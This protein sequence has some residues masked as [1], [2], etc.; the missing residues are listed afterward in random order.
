[1]FEYTTSWTQLSFNR[2]HLAFY[3]FNPVTLSSHPSAWHIPLDTN[4]NV[5]RCMSRFHCDSWYCRPLKSCSRWY[6]ASFRLAFGR[7]NQLCYDAILYYWCFYF[8]PMNREFVMWDNAQF[9]LNCELQDGNTTSPPT[10]I[11]LRIRA[12]ESSTPKSL[13]VS[14]IWKLLLKQNDQLH[15]RR[16]SQRVMDVSQDLGEPHKIPSEDALPSNTSHLGKGKW[17]SKVPW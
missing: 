13:N 16:I 12:G 17:S 7:K 15:G 6:V 5:G 11:F 3:D 9:P 2:G 14:G 10:M 4:K 1:M 8:I